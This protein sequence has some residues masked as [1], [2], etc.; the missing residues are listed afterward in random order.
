[1]AFIKHPLGKTFY[2]SKG[3][4]SRDIPLICL[5]GGPGGMSLALEPLLKLS[6]ERKVFIYDQIGG[7]RSSETIKP[8][9]KIQTF[10]NELDHLLDTWNIDEFHLFGASWGTTL[11]LEYYL[12]RKSKRKIKSLIFQ[13]P[14][15]SAKIWEEDANRL[16]KKFPKE[17][18]KIIKYCHDINATDS[19]VYKQA[20]FDYYLRHVLRNKKKLAAKSKFK[21]DHGNRVYEY[22]WGPSEFKAMGS[23]KTY[24]QVSKLKTISIPSLFICGEYDEATPRSTKRF[25]KEVK[26]SR[27]KMIPNASH[28][29]LSERPSAMLSEIKLFL[30]DV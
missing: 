1:M 5:H 4:L 27:F 13:S 7:G 24:D 6:S 22:M 21:N 20:V 8:N 12:R 15:F 2:K 26:D 30:K 29:I 11:A 28:A 3:S 25:A 17:T 16:I 19:K 23:L 14:M 18:Q 10:V 9:W